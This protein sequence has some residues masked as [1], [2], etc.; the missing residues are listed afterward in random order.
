[1]R[2]Q[3]H[4]IDIGDVSKRKK[5]RE[6][7]QCKPFKWYLDN[8]YPSLETLDNILGYGVLQ[9][10]LLQQY[11]VD[12]G[13]VPGSIPIL[14]ECHFEQPQLC[15]YNT[16]GEIIIGEIKSHKYNNN[17]C[18]VDPG[19]GSAPTLHECHLAKLKQLHMH[20]DFK[21]QIQGYSLRM[22]IWNQI[23]QVQADTVE[24]LFN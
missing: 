11:C 24:R 14:Y 3:N 8:V 22:D 21:Q 13:A 19:S 7:L 16:D 2:D 17:R 12:Q 6:K 23:C 5:L 15:Y 20:W 9:N 1:M 18:L 4:G 10:T